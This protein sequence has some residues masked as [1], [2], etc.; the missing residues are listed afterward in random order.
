MGQY[1]T[2]KTYA[3]CPTVDLEK[4]EE[5]DDEEEPPY[6]QCRRA[7]LLS[8]KRASPMLSTWRGLLVDN[9]L[10]LHVYLKT[11]CW[12]EI[13]DLEQL[14]DVIT[15]E[16]DTLN[17]LTVDMDIYTLERALREKFDYYQ[18]KQTQ[19]VKWARKNG[20]PYLKKVVA[21]KQRDE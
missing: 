12:D 20:P 14:L 8:I 18:F 15:N 3:E 5:E 19:F 13:H 7:L 9:T 4:G 21:D 17:S 11:S 10:R 6:L 2:S 16:G 1:Q